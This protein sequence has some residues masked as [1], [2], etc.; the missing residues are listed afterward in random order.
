MRLKIKKLN[1]DAVSPK[2]A[3]T[4]DAG[5]DL[6]SCEDLVIKSGERGG[7]S[8]GISF[9][10]PEGYVGLVWDKSGLAFKNGIHTMAGVLDS[11]YRGELKI[12]L[13]NFGEEDFII[14]KGQKV[15]QLLIQKIE[16]PEIVE[17]EKLS[18]AERGERG[19]GSTG[20]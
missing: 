15:A 13:I 11:G 9:E 20:R 19:F 18:E 17:V 8:T 5:M 14:K 16:N 7:V 3:L 2:Y 6:F 12:A 4:G 10:V 1:K